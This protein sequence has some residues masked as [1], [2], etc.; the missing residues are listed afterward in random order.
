MKKNLSILA[1]VAL[2]FGCTNKTKTHQPLQNE[3]LAYTYKF[4][5]IQNNQR[6]LAIATYLNPIL[7][8]QN[9]NEIFILSSYP[10]EEEILINSIKVNG[11]SNVDVSKL[12]NDDEILNFINI[13]LPWSNHYKI[14]APQ[15]NSD[16]LEITYKTN[17]STLAK[18]KFQKVSKSMHWSPKI[19]FESK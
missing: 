14:T 3:L 19:K 12:K 18:L 5:K 9:Q 6:Y 1:I 16:Y 2:F 8:D 7:K 15:K 4:E 11:D 17:L 10:K 13:K